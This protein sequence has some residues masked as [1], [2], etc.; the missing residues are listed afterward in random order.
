MRPTLD[1]VGII[2]NQ[3]GKRVETAGHTSFIKI[4]DCFKIKVETSD[5]SIEAR[6]AFDKYA[7]H[8]LFK[9]F[10]TDGDMDVKNVKSVNILFLWKHEAE[11]FE[12][13]G[14]KCGLI[15]GATACCWRESLDNAF[16]RLLKQ[17]N[18]VEEESGLVLI[19]QFV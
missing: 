19:N 6:E 8:Y 10:N 16:D 17:Y 15:N 11:Q 2:R 18:L 3:L 4:Y 13:S 5:M 7:G 12:N 1:M 9:T 14:I